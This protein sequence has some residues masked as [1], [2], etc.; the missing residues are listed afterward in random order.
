MSLIALKLCNTNDFRVYA[1]P[2]RA[3]PAQ[4][5]AWMPLELF[6]GIAPRAAG[7]LKWS[8]DKDS[9]VNYG[10]AK[11]DAKKKI[12]AF[13]EICGTSSTDKAA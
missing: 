13:E 7:Y 9:G 2:A 10:L 11:E 3:S 8:K 12:K 1:R 4:W 6:V 5:D